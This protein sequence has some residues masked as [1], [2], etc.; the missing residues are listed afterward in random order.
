MSR[1]GTRSSSW[2]RV[3]PD[4]TTNAFS[5]GRHLH[6]LVLCVMMMCVLWWIVQVH[7]SITPITHTVP[8]SSRYPQTTVH[9]IL[10]IH[11]HIQYSQS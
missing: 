6:L 9:R 3:E 5:I 2:K 11:V 8:V 1:V 10:L 7:S 4:L